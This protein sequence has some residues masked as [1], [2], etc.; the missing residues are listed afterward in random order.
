M[1]SEKVSNFVLDPQFDISKLIAFDKTISIGYSSSE[2][3]YSFLYF[4]VVYMTICLILS[5]NEIL[6]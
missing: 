6:L 3:D 5:F 1:H 2:D 4:S